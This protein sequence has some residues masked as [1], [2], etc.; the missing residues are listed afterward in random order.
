MVSIERLNRGDRIRLQICMFVH[1]FMFVPVVIK[2]ITDV[3][4]VPATSQAL[5]WEYVWSSSCPV[6]IYGL[7]IVR[8]DDYRAAQ[9]LAFSVAYALLAVLPIIVAVSTHLYQLCH[10]YPVDL[11]WYFF[12]VLALPVHCLCFYYASTMKTRLHV[13]DTKM[14]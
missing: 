6:V 11:N 7:L 13:A 5:T 2:V 12:E 1:L 14:C 8:N 9:L 3:W 4:D 10:G